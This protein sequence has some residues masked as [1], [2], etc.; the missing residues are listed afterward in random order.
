MLV[1]TAVLTMLV[2]TAVQNDVGG[3]DQLS[4][5]GQPVLMAGARRRTELQH[6]RLRQ[7]RRRLVEPLEADVDTC[8]THPQA[9]LSCVTSYI[10]SLTKIN[11]GREK[12]DGWP[13]QQSI[14]TTCTGNVKRKNT[15]RTNI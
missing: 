1:L 6:Q 12:P 10:L 15:A 5:L 2:L 11:V 8:K 3:V 4:E 13:L 9:L 7:A 14:F